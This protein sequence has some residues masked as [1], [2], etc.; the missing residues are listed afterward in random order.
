[1]L[2]ALVASLLMLVMVLLAFGKRPE[3]EETVIVNNI[4]RKE[5]L[6]QD[7]DGWARSTGF[8]SFSHYL[9][10]KRA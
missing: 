4:S 10:N 1:M 5:C 2:P 6:I 9:A 7:L 3:H 8:T